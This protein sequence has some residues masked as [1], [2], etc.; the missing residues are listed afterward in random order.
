MTVTT[1]TRYQGS[2]PAHPSIFC[3]SNPIRPWLTCRL[4]EVINREDRGH[5]RGSIMKKRRRGRP[6]LLV[7][8]IKSL[9]LF[10]IP[11]LRWSRCRQEWLLGSIDRCELSKSVPCSRHKTE[12]NCRWDPRRIGPIERHCRHRW[13]LWEAHKSA[14]IHGTGGWR[15]RIEK[16]GQTAFAAGIWNLRPVWAPKGLKTPRTQNTN[17]QIQATAKHHLRSLQGEPL[18]CSEQS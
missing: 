9:Q 6:K 18:W 16:V 5:S 3:G 14:G 7:C 13:F 8:S 10:Q 2:N 11:C 12:L 1:Y 17:T 15:R 4:I